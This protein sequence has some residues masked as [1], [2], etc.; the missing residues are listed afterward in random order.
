M[1]WS[2]SGRRRPRRFHSEDIGGSVARGPETEVPT[3]KATRSLSLDQVAEKAAAC[4]RAT[5]PP[6]FL[7]AFDVPN[8]DDDQEQDDDDD[9]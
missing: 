4:P 5:A 6:M 9:A 3:F 1:T 8:E 7:S 2:G